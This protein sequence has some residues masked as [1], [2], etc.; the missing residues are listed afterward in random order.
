M[1]LRRRRRLHV[2]ACGASA[3]Q[4]DERYCAEPHFAALTAFAAFAAPGVASTKTANSPVPFGDRPQLTSASGCSHSVE[5]TSVPSSAN[6]ATPSPPLLN[7]NG[8]S[9]P[10]VSTRYLPAPSSVPFAIVAFAPVT[11]KTSWKYTPLR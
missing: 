5:S 1:R 2:G 10:F 7:P 9:V 8:N 6:S 4:E 11:G 3:A